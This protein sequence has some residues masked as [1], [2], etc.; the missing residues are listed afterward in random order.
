VQE[1]KTL[2]HLLDVNNNKLFRNFAELL[3]ERVETTV[4]NVLEHDVQMVFGVNAV[5]V[6]YYFGVLQ[7]FKQ[8][9]FALQG[10]FSVFFYEIERDLLYSN[11]LAVLDVEAFEDFAASSTSN[12]LAYLIGSDAFGF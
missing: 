1:L 9:Y 2:Q 7:F 8:V 11:E 10:A 4:L 12:D 3:Y 5:N 6:F